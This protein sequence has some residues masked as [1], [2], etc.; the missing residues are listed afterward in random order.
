MAICTHVET[1]LPDKS[2][3]AV[4]LGNFDFS[5][6]ILKGGRAYTRSFQDL[7][8]EGIAAGVVGDLDPQ[9][10]TYVILGLCNSVARWYPPRG[11]SRPRRSES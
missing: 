3:I 1:V 5:G 7:I 6:E 9:T 2:I 11:V 4:L 8:E 10:S